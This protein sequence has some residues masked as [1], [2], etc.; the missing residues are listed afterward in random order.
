MLQKKYVNNKMFDA[1]NPG[2]IDAPTGQRIMETRFDPD[3]TVELLLQSHYVEQLVKNS[4]TNGGWLTGGSMKNTQNIVLSMGKD[5][6]RVL[7]TYGM[8]ACEALRQNHR[9]DLPTAGNLHKAVE[10]L[11]ERKLARKTIKHV[12]KVAISAPMRRI[13]RNTREERELQ[14]ILYPLE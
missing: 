7:F 1:F 12:T 4:H 13:T 14:R 11:R 5:A 10:W 8:G 9:P 6:I 3:D 2:I